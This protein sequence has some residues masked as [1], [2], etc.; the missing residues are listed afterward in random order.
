MRRLAIAMAFFVPA[1]GASAMASAQ[2]TATIN[3]R[4]MQCFTLYELM[5]DEKQ[6]DEFQAKVLKDQAIFMATI[7]I[8]HNASSKPDYEQDEFNRI[9]EFTKGA[10]IELARND[11]SAVAD[12]LVQCEGWREDLVRHYVIEGSKSDSEGK[13]L[14]II[15]SV[16]E[17]K[18][19]YSL[20]GATPDQVVSAVNS[21]FKQHLDSE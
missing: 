5:V 8:I 13:D 7:N 18:S 9:W 14:D 16:P 2:P 20:T 19:D 6:Q 3:N 1:I 11:P 15:L 21:S 17:P 10:M 4:S 12:R